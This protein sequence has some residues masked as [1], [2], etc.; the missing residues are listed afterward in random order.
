M[1]SFRWSRDDRRSGEQEWWAGA[2][3]VV[4]PKSERAERQMQPV[5]HVVEE[6]TA[7]HETLAGHGN[8][9]AREVFLTT[10]I[11]MMGG[12]ADRRR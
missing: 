9:P 8:P 11:L 12:V 6:P 10:A 4:T 7:V 1:T 5:G 2:I 3:E